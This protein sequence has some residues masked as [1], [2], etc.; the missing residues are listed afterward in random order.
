MTPEQA[1]AAATAMRFLADALR[2]DN[3]LETVGAF[4]L[5]Q[6]MAA[7]L[8]LDLAINA[9]R[10]M[11]LDPPEFGGPEALAIYVNAVR[12]SEITRLNT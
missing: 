2:E 6:P 10:G 12:F 8:C 4:V 5:D 1:D 3:D 9:L 11:V 7:A